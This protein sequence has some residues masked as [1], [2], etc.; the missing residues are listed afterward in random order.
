MF[1]RDVGDQ[2]RA[3]FILRTVELVAAAILSEV[4]CVRGSEKRALVMVKPPGDARR[5]GIFEIHDGIFVA[6]EQRFGKGMSRL[7]RHSR[8]MEFRPGMDAFPEK[9]VKHG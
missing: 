8:K 4:L 1:A 7:V 2:F 5:A 6:V 3:G 9:P